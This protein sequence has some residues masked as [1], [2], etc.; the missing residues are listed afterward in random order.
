MNEKELI[1]Y[2]DELLFNQTGKHLNNLQ[3]S[4]LNGVLNSKKYSD[5]AKDYSCTTG[6]ARDKGYELLKILSEALGED[7]NKSNFKA[8]IERLGFANIRSPI[9]GNKVK[10]RNINL[11]SNSATNEIKDLSV[12]ENRENNKQDLE[13]KINVKN[14]EKLRELGLTK[15][16]I[17]EALDLSLQEIEKA[18]I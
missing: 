4:I 16:Q 17:A 8:T 18:I 6:H 15:E 10:V 13:L 9:L 14:I 5:I 7:I 12:K 2:L 3:L 11:C 1:N